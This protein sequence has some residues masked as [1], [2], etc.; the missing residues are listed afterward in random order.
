MKTEKAREI[1]RDIYGTVVS[2]LKKAGIESNENVSFKGKIK[3]SF[4]VD[5]GLSVREYADGSKELI[6][7]LEE[8]DWND[9]DFGKD[10]I[11]NEMLGVITLE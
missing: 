10:G 6:F 3:K 1:S 7:S 4:N 9:V 8:G 2:M 5:I 11:N